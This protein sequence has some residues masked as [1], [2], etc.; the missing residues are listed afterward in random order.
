MNRI[1]P[2]IKEDKSQ[3]DGPY[4]LTRSKQVNFIPI[5]VRNQIQQDYKDISKRLP[6][7]ANALR[8]ELERLNSNL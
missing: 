8:Y 7:S 1:P 5:W 2:V 3:D 4:E 6:V